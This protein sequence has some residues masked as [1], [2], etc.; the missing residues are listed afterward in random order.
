MMTPET[1]FG[2][3]QTKF[4]ENPDLSDKVKAVYQFVLTGDGGGSWW[5]DLLS[6]PGVVGK[7]EKKE[8]NCVITMAS[9]DFVGLATK[10]ANAVKLFM[11][12]KLKIGGD[13]SAAMKIQN[14]L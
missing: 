10:E 6:K 5:V 1:I 11:S 3:L 14:V 7:G 12:G 13:L 4:N 8:A 9:E 2:K